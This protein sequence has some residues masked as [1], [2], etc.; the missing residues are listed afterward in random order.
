MPWAVLAVHLAACTAT[1]G[2]DAAHLAPSWVGPSVSKKCSLLSH[3]WYKLH[4]YRT[5]GTYRPTLTFQ[6]RPVLLARG[7]ADL[8]GH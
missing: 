5:H 4:I 3:L 8:V 7:R 6:S 1:M 2:Q